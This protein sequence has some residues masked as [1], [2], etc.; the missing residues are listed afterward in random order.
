MAVCN[1]A[2]VEARSI[3]NSISCA[4]MNA[5]SLAGVVSESSPGLRHLLD[6]N[7]SFGRDAHNLG[8]NARRW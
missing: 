1:A 7:P 8:G 2:H 5:R 3:G 4:S 6:G